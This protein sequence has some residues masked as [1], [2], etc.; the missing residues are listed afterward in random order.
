MDIHICI[1][2]YVYIYML[3]CIHQYVYMMSTKSLL[4]SPTPLLPAPS[5]H[6]Q[7]GLHFQP[8]LHEAGDP[9]S[10]TARG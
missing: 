7:A 5:S 9:R 3:L 10:P 6:G 4:K 2:T 1:N 8:G